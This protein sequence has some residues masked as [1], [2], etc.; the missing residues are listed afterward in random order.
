[1]KKRFRAIALTVSAMLL[2]VLCPVPRTA[3]ATAITVTADK[4]EAE[5][6]DI[7]TFTIDMGPVAEL[8]TLQ[9][10]LDIPEGLTYVPGSGELA[11]DLRQTLG[12]D[13][14]EFTE[15][16]LMILG[17]ASR[18]DYSSTDDTRLFT[19]QCTVD[20]GFSGTV[21]L[22]LTELEFYSCMTW[23]DHTDEFIV[24][25]AVVYIPGGSGGDEAKET[26]SSA[27]RNSSGSSGE[28]SSNSFPK[29]FRGLHKRPLKKEEGS[30]RPAVRPEGNSVSV[31]GTE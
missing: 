1:M 17:V 5:P 16:S 29:N 22:G 8:G 11:P 14:L 19:F 30:K 24:N 25:E 20:E 31:R 27:D 3:A 10:M 7:V 28:T 26:D 2:F 4:T 15:V 12:Y 21:R 9:M 6:G 23:I 18:Q 13:I